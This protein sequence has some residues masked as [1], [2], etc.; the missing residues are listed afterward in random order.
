LEEEEGNSPLC[1]HL[2]EVCPFDGSRGRELTI[3]G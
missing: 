2:D 3:V 1:A